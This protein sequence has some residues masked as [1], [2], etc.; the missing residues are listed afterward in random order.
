M[1]ERDVLSQI[2]VENCHC[3]VPK[4]DEKTENEYLVRG[5]GAAFMRH[6]K[7]SHGNYLLFLNFIIWGSMTHSSR[8]LDFFFLKKTD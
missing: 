6:R 2:L 8:Y 7:P 5:A 3:T 4:K 1:I